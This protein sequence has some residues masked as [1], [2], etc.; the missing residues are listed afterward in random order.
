MVLSDGEEF[1]AGLI[2]WTA[3]NGANPVVAK[4]TDL[5]VDERGLIIV[6]ADLRVGT[7]SR[8]TG[9]RDAWAAGDDA[10]VP[11]LAS[12][13]PGAR[14]VPNAQH[15][16]RQGKQLGGQPV[17]AIAGRHPATLRSPHPR[18]RRDAGLGRGIFQYRR[19]V[20]K[21]CWPG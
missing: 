3:G 12:P 7:G 8:R 21:G 13:T 10:A 15:A 16:V 14:T 19:I 2:V 1:D 9:G 17:A 5:P 20:I 11:D 6:R 4:H 18:R